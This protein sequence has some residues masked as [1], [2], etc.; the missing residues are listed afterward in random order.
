VEIHHT[1]DSELRAQL[2]HRESAYRRVLD[3]LKAPVPAVAN[4]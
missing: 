2:I 3:K 1:H 4:V